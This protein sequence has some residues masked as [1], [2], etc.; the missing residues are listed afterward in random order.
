VNYLD[1]LIKRLSE[2]GIRLNNIGEFPLRNLVREA[3]NVLQE[4]RETRDSLEELLGVLLLEYHNG[5]WLSGDNKT[6][7]EAERELLGK[8]LHSLGTP[9]PST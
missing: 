8:C 9:H 3:R 2:A 4:L 5:C 1:D 6:R 7:N